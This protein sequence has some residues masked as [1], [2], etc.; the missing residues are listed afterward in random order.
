MNKPKVNYTYT[1]LTET[2]LVLNY[3]YGHCYKWILLQLVVLSITD[4]HKR[5]LLEWIVKHPL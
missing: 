3:Y 1:L 5:G 4:I 2:P